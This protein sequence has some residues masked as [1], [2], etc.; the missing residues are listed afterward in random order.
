MYIGIDLGSTNIKAALYDGEMKLVSR[1]S[2]PVSYIREQGFV[3]FDAKEYVNNLIKLLSEILK[4]NKIESVNEMAFTGQAESLVVVGNDGN[5]LMNAISWM[6]ERSVEEC[7]ELTKLFS[8]EECESITGQQAVLPTWPATK[9]L[10]LKKNK[11]EVYDNAKTYMLLKDYVIFAL[12]G[13][14]VSD[15]SIATFSFYFDIYKKCYWKK[16]LDAIGIGEDKLPVLCEPCTVAGVLKADIA[17][18]LGL[19]GETKIN[20]GTLDHFAGMIGTGNIG[21][22]KITLSTGTVMAMATFS[23]E[24]CDDIRGI[25]MHYGFLPDTHIMLPVAESGG[26]SLEWFKNSCLKDVS[27]KDIDA[28]AEKRRGNELLFLPYIVGTN[29]PEFDSRAT[30]V[31]WGLRGEHDAYDMALAVM[32]GVGFLLKKNLLYIKK[33]GTD[34]KAIIATGGGSKSALWCQ[35][36][37]DITDIPIMVPKEKEAA[38]LGAAIIAAV[39]DGKIKSYKEAAESIEF[40]K[41]YNPL[42]DKKLDGKFE[43][44]NALYEFSCALKDGGDINEQN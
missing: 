25:A 20:V 41:V 38:C 22:G 11:R 40:E 28:E 2:F 16:M 19:S 1:K 32:E 3:E 43:K 14:K 6:D 21:E 7:A 24:P 29:S 31:F 15:M 12:T 30:G 42:K 26:V 27:F 18:M 34:A 9:I 5:P 8:K 39:S 35:L 36:Q 37:A 13:K 44:F 23:K 10:W 4:E 17:K 33:N